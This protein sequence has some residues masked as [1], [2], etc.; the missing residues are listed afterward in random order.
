MNGTV[1][2][3]F[4]GEYNT[5]TIKTRDLRCEFAW[6]I[7]VNFM[8]EVQNDV[9]NMKICESGFLNFMLKSKNDYLDM[10]FWA[11]KA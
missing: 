8:S 11:F 3:Q 4:E 2:W 5:F 7:I 1:E 9:Y 6:A 10:K